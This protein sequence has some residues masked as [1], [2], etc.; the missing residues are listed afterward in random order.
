MFAVG[1]MALA[2]LISKTSAKTLNINPN[3]P[4]ILVLSIIPDIDILLG[5]NE[6]HRGPTHSTIAALLIFIPLFAIYRKKATPYFLALLSHSLIGDLIIGGNLQLLWPIR[7]NEISL[8]PL[9][10]NIAINSPINIALELTL[11]TAATIVMLKTKD[12]HLFLQNKKTNLLLAIPI[13]TVLLP[14]FLAYPLNVPPILIAPHL[15]Y[16]ALFTI[17][18]SAVLSSFFKKPP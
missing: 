13:S 2:Y 16:L 12:L 14:T 3:I 17:A 15:F 4:A 10:P 5:I 6:F 1:H 11:F 9:L 18:L 7:P 8:S